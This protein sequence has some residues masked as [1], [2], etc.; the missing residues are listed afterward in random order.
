MSHSRRT[1]L[2]QVAQGTLMLGALPLALDRLPAEFRPA[3]ASAANDT[4]NITW[5]KRLTGRVRACFDVAELES[6]YGV[7]RASVWARQFEDAAGVPFKA[8]STALVL[9]HNA[10]ALAMT[11]AFWEKYAIG[12]ESK[13]MHP[14]TGEPTTRNPALLGTADG[15]PEPYNRFTLDKFLATGGVALACNLALRDMADIVKKV[16]GVAEEKAHEIARAALVP[17]VILQP[18]GVFAAIL[19]QTAGAHYIRAS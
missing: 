16:D 13:A 19:A 2:D 18:S 4:W 6:G 8:T 12:P 3:P 15:V 5:T 11:H 1:F 7:W 14:I 9:R 10:I 17:G